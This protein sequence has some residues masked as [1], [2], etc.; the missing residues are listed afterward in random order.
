MSGEKLGI[1]YR[2]NREHLFPIPTYTTESTGIPLPET[3]DFLSSQDPH[4]TQ[5]LGPIIDDSYVQQNLVK[6][7]RRLHDGSMTDNRRMG[8]E[9]AL[10]GFLFEKAAYNY[11]EQGIQGDAQ[12]L[13]PLQ[14]ERLFEIPGLKS[15]IRERVKT[16]PDGLVLQPFH[17]Q[18]YIVGTC[19]YTLRAHLGNPNF[20]YR[21]MN[22]DKHKQIMQH[23]TGKVV[24]DLYT[25]QD[26]DTQQ[27]LGNIINNMYPELPPQLAYSEKAFK[28]ILVTP[29]EDDMPFRNDKC[30]LVRLPISSTD[31]WYLSMSL[32]T[33][34]ENAPAFYESTSAS[35]FEAAD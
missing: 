24:Y 29:T 1:S 14:T 22:R 35:R 32:I 25:R 23:V 8:L 28:A 30:D 10:S 6:L 9:N 17:D 5:I 31:F 3:H 26:P 2:P 12:L 34:L 27:C 21:A 20:P 33:E 15:R 7:Q 11:L 19:E 4:K 16:I 18:T 13:N